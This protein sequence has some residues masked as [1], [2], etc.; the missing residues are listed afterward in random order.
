[1]DLVFYNGHFYQLL[2]PPSSL[3]G[4]VDKEQAWHRKVASWLPHFYPDH[5]RDF[6]CTFM[7]SYS[8]PVM[9]K[10]RLLVKTDKSASVNTKGCFLL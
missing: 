2:G 3:T 8:K 6:L 7:D 1:M 10:F 5:L 9:P 4:R